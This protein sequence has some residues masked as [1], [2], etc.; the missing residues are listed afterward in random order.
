MDGTGSEVLVPSARSSPIPFTTED[1]ARACEDCHR[2]YC[3]N[4]SSPYQPQAEK[5]TLSSFAQNGRNNMCKW[6]KLYPW[7]T[8]CKERKKVFCFYGK[9]ATHH[10]LLMFNK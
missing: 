4:I 2:P 3:S 7:L 1:E 10:G 5:E 9:Y 8:V 6:Y